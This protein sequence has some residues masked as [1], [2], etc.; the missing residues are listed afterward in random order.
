MSE[1]RFLEESER[2]KER[3]RKRAE[4]NKVSDGM[5]VKKRDVARKPFLFH[6][7]IESLIRRRKER[8]V[9]ECVCV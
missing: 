1:T 3:E 4:G 9:S 7:C 6:P 2:T 5:N 8:G